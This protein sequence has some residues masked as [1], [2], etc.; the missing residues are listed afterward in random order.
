MELSDWTARMTPSAKRHTLLGLREV[1]IR[2][3][4]GGKE[5]PWGWR[6]GPH[7]DGIHVCVQYRAPKLADLT[8]ENLASA[9]RCSSCDRPMIDHLM[10][11]EPVPKPIYQK[12]PVAQ[13][14]TTTE[15]NVATPTQWAYA[16]VQQQPERDAGLLDEINDPLAINSRPTPM[17]AMPTRSHGKAA[18]DAAAFK[19]EVERMVHE[20]NARE[21]RSGVGAGGV[22]SADAFKLEVE[23][24]VREA[25]ARDGTR[26]GAASAAGAASI[27]AAEEEEEL[28]LMRQLEA[29]RARKAAAAAR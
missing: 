29:V 2:C 25:N 11:E 23:R 9:Y 6:R 12:S 16:P 24:M 22:A 3:P 21:G 19:L 8:E 5:D 26:G 13:A 27:A 4:A 17:P 28:Q 10:E 7:K 18:D 14:A 20:A 1:A 15:R